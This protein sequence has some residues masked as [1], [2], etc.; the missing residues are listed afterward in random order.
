MHLE[1]LG[2]AHLSLPVLNNDQL[3]RRVT[4][5]SAQQMRHFRQW[6]ICHERAALGWTGGFRPL[7]GGS[8]HAVISDDAAA[9]GKYE[10][11]G[12]ETGTE[13]GI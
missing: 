3:P 6:K 8:F 10:G 13:E 12:R 5:A 7:I 9:R 11:E 2:E 4:W 1:A